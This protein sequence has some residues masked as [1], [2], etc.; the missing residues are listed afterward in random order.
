MSPEESCVEWKAYDVCTISSTNADC[1]ICASVFYKMAFEASG[2]PV[3]NAHSLQKG[4]RIHDAIAQSEVAAVTWSKSGKYKAS[5]GWFRCKSCLSLDIYSVAL[6]CFLQSG[7]S[8]VVY[9]Y[10][11]VVC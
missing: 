9:C 5:W 4:R 6:L 1:K 8:Y 10:V 2:H 7:L 3:H 11:F